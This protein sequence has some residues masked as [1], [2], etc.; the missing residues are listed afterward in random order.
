M[1]TEG[2]PPQSVAQAT[3]PSGEMKPNQE[4]MLQ[5]LKEKIKEEAK[6]LGY[7]P[8][9]HTREGA[10]PAHPGQLGYVPGQHTR[11][12]ASPSHPG[13][14]QAP[15]TSGAAVDG[16]NVKKVGDAKAV[17]EGAKPSGTDEDKPDD[18]DELAD[19]FSMSLY[20]DFVFFY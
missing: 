10:S 11:E 7:V 13:Q 5:E 17:G 12:G 18:T 2:F 14:S 16:S 9:Q 15:T 19:F 6:K 3:T 20:C 4:A 1:T 8:G